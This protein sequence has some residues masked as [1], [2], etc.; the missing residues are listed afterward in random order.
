[1]AVGSD[2]TLGVMGGVVGQ[3]GEQ[4]IAHHWRLLAQSGS[5]EWP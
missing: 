4:L 3:L 2:R 1:M 5:S